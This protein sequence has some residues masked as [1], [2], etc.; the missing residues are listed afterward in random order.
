MPWQTTYV[1]P[2]VFLRFRGVTVYHTYKNDDINQGTRTYSF[3]LSRDCA[4][5]SC[6]CER[7]PCKNL[8]DVRGLPNWSEPPHPPFL[9]A[10]N[11]A[12]NQKAWA[13]YHANR[14]EEKHIRRVLREATRQGFLV[15]G[16]GVVKKPAP[17]RRR[18]R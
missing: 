14:T 12:A 1:E 6:S 15:P 16:R 7:A 11:I 9:T 5:D 3:T 8:F 10:A 4:E 2:E 17:K 18:R 13:R